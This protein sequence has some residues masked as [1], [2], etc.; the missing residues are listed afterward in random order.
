MGKPSG[1]GSTIRGDETDDKFRK[2][3]SKRSS[4]GNVSRGADAVSKIPSRPDDAS[5]EAGWH[6]I[7]AAAPA[8]APHVSSSHERSGDG[9]THESDVFNRTPSWASRH[10]AA[11]SDGRT[12]GHD[13]TV[14]KT[15]SRN[16]GISKKEGRREVAATPAIEPPHERSGDSHTHG[17]R[18][19]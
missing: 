17:S 3:H 5:N 8:I 14:A 2:S 7:S 10:E 6:A 11:A 19:F 4:D 18:G 16:D 12:P 1:D 13:D 15:R 9:R